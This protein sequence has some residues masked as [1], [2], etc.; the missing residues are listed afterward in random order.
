MFLEKSLPAG[1]SLK[2]NADSA[3]R[4]RSFGRL[5]FLMEEYSRRRRF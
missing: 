5:A 1:G 2:T 3:V 4:V